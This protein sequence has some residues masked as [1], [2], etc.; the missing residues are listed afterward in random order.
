MLGKFYCVKKWN[1][2]RLKNV[3]NKM[4]LQFMYIYLIYKYEQDLT[5]NTENIEKYRNNENIRI[6]RIQE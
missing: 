1:L 6:L 3:I 5:L 2:V 4:C